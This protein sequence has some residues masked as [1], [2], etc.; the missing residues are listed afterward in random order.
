[1]GDFNAQPFSVPI[2]I[3]RS[4][5]G[6]TDSFLET[7]PT[8]NDASSSRPSA[9]EAIQ[10]FGMTCDSPLNT[11]SAGKPIPDNISSQGGKRLDYIFYRQPAVARRRPL[12]WGYRDDAVNSFSEGEAELEEGKPMPKSLE[13][14]P[15]LRC[16]KSE[17]ILTEN[18]PGQRFS[19]S[20][21]FALLSTFRIDTP[22]HAHSDTKA[23]NGSKDTKFTPLVPLLNEPEPLNDT[24]TTFAPIPSGQSPRVNQESASSTDEKSAV[25]RSAL[26]TLRLYTRI[27]QHT[28]KQH[29]RFFG[30]AVLALIALTV[31]SAWQPKSWLQP[32]FTLLGGLLG[33]AGATF[34]YT[35]FVW[36]RWE[37]G[38]LTETTEE[39]ELE[40]RVV[41]M[42]ERGRE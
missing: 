16:V 12:I 24:T 4:H 15:Q 3:L 39:M 11:Y 34:L 29:L 35:G 9:Q 5:A 10:S 36:G 17:V 28:A 18:V 22:D 13:T 1:M 21:H 26:N 27:S 31:G 20:D 8:A 37:L 7:H 14:A 32:I 19:Y 25:I 23:G 30:G 40:L 6:L 41:E 42:E 38:L 2:A 33:A